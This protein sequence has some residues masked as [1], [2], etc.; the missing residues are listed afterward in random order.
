M[1]LL[2]L[3]TSVSVSLTNSGYHLR[4]GTGTKFGAYL[5][6]SPMLFKHKMNISWPIMKNKVT[7]NEYSLY[8]T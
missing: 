7:N 3:P 8:S 2:M 4:T 1:R 6:P 5:S